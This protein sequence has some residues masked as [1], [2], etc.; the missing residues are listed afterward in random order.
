MKNSNMKGHW[1]GI[2]TERDA[3]TGIDFIEDVIPKK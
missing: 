2:L 1:T 3:K